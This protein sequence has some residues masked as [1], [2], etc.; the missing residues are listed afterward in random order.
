MA[1]EPL[2]LEPSPRIVPVVD[3]RPMIPEPPPVKLVVIADPTLLAPTGIEEPLDSFYLDLLKFWRDPSGRLAYRAENFTVR[4]EIVEP[5]VCRD[6][7][8]MLGIVVRSLDDVEKRLR[9]AGI[10]V[11]RE[12]DLAPGIECLVVTDP[13]GNGLRLSEVHLL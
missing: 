2:E 11:S 4:F 8:R 12:R 3:G 13:A 10:A 1:I 9:E 6:D 7:Y 5:P